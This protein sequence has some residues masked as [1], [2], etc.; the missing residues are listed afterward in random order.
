MNA[1]NALLGVPSTGVQVSVQALPT[2]TGSTP[3]YVA[4]FQD[5]THLS[6][7]FL[8]IPTGGTPSFEIPG[9]TTATVYCF[10]RTQNPLQPTTS[11]VQCMYYAW[12]NPGAGAGGGASIKPTML[13]TP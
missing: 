9:F 11:P 13:F 7:Y 12:V 4:S 8:P 5:T 10:A 1:N 2:T 6:W 3:Q